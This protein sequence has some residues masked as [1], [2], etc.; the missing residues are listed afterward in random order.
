MRGDIDVLSYK[1]RDDL[2]ELDDNHSGQM[3]DSV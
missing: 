3:I 2:Q 1:G